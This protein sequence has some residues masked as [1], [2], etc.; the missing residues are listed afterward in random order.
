MHPF[1]VLVPVGAAGLD[2]ASKAQGE[3]VRTI[4]LVRTASLRPSASDASVRLRSRGEGEVEGGGE[5][6][7]N[8]SVPT[9]GA[10]V[11]AGALPGR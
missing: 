8:A 6:F 10:E 2:R 3:Q 1:Q 9:L 4:A 11:A 7:G 5:R